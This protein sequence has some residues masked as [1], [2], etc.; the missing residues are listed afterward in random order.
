MSTSIAAPA[1]ALSSMALIKASSLINPPLAVLIN[2]ADDFI[3]L[4]ALSSNNPSVLSVNGQC[5]LI[6]SDS[7][8][9]VSKEIRLR[10]SSGFLSLAKLSQT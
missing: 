3:F 5:R 10:S 6:M 7:V 4:K 9:K 2:I 1:I 8:K